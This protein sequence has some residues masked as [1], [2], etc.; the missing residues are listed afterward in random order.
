M[1]RDS[2]AGAYSHP[3]GIAALAG[4]RATSRFVLVNGE[5][6]RVLVAPG[7]LLPDLHEHVV[8]QARRAESVSVGSEPR[9]PKGLVDL[10]EVLHRLLP[11]PDAARRLPPH[12]PPRLLLPVANHL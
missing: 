3:L 6:V 10:D 12:D 5:V 11:L 2:G 8:E 9:E 1:S 7:P 4:L